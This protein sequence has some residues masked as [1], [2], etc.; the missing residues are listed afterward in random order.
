MPQF[1]IE[2]THEITGE[3][4]RLSPGEVNWVSQQQHEKYG[5]R[6]GKWTRETA[7][8]MVDNNMPFGWSYKLVP[9]PP[10]IKITV[11][12]GKSS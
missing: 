1:Y 6:Y 10:K 4:F 2:R 3:S 7:E 5:T 11:S 12:H 9:V 8:K